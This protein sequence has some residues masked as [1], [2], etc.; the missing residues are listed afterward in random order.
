MTPIAVVGM[1]MISPL[2]R[3]PAEHAF[4]LRA[5]VGPAASGAFLDDQG[6]T[7]PVAYCPW[8]GARQPPSE[9][10]LALGGAALESAL[11]PWRRHLDAI[12]SKRWPA[13][14]ALFVCT[15]A[16]RT[17]LDDADRKAA[18]EALSSSVEGQRCTQLTGEAG[19]FQGLAEASALLERRAARAVAIV[20]VDS[21]ISPAAIAEHRQRATTPWESNLPRPAEA[22]AA[23]LLM[24][25][26]D[27]KQQS[28]G[29]LAIVH[30]SATMR[31]EAN[32]DNDAVVDGAAMT[33][34]LGSIRGLGQPIGA[35]FGQHGKGGLRR[36][37][38]EIAAARCVERFEPTCPFL[39]VE[40]EIGCFGAAAGAANFVYGIAVHRHRTW[41]DAPRAEDPF[42]AWAISRDGI[43]G[44][45]TATARGRA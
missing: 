17:G 42:V 18:E 28:L 10:L 3:S 14:V 7:I 16:P 8:L 1:G 2:G 24:L 21:L 43:R 4:F 25:P 36:R 26:D 9:R 30:Q 44:L 19:F 35:S 33:A 37:E 39:C 41:P 13:P 15:A 12:S 40:R 38:W 23:V 11:E 29:M 34:L 45:C 32:D 27:A 31:G 22:A 5:E 20:A 6:E